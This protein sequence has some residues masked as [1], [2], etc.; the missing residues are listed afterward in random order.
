MFHFIK[1]KLQT[2]L[3]SSDII[4][5]YKSNSTNIIYNLIFADDVELYKANSNQSNNTYPWDIIFSKQFDEEGL[6]RIINDNKTESRVKIIAYNELRRKNKKIEKQDILG[7]VIEVE[8]DNKGLDVLAVYKDK[9]IRYIN[10][11][12]KMIFWDAESTSINKHIEDLFKSADHILKKIG[13]WDQARLPQP[14]K[15]NARITFLVSDG[16]YFG[17]GSLNA[18]ASEPLSKPLFDTAVIIMKFVTD[19]AL[20]SQE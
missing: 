9:T 5:P 10:Y 4:K 11:S 2:T 12:E 3:L 1:S 17:E 8:I 20:S 13:P 7:V 6:N 15:G 14:K 19:K 18:I 16:L